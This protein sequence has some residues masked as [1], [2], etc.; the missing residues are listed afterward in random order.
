MALQE[1]YKELIDV[2]T[3]AGVNEL[4]VREQDGVLY[5]DGAT[6]GTVK[7]QLWDTYERLDPNYASGDVVMNINSVAGVADG[8][9]L[10]VTTNSSNLNIRKGPSTNDD[11]IGKAAR[12]EVV[13]LVGKENDQWW[14]IKTDQG[15][16][17]YS[18]TQYL[19]PVE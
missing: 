3:A 19:T 12:H 13:T 9:K 15:E 11:I 14:L 1:K 7:Q 16:Q 6:S 8:S 4:N 18:F 5:I 17:G 10:K 2:A